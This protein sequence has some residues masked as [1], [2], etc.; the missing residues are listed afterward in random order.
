M[1]RVLLI[2]VALFLFSTPSFSAVSTSDGVIT[3]DFYEDT[4][5]GI[6]NLWII[7]FSFND[8]DG[9]GGL[10]EIE[11]SLLFMNNITHGNRLKIGRKSD[12]KSA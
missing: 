4:Q 7:D 6:E 10:E 5:S 3:L 12:K 11:F 2:A 9:P 1:K 8:I